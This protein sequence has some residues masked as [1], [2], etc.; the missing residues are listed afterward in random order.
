[1]QINLVDDTN[2]KVGIIKVNNIVDVMNIIN[3]I[4]T[5]I[6]DNIEYEKD[7]TS[8]CYKCYYDMDNSEVTIFLKQI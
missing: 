2:K 3:S 1:M 6:I 8:V 7:K 4:E 5:F